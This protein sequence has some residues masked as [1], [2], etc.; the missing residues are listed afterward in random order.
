MF[1]FLQVKYQLVMELSHFQPPD[2]CIPRTRRNA[3]RIE[4]SITQDKGKIGAGT[5]LEKPS[6]MAPTT[7]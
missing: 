1:A 4:V 7:S 3:G 2:R 5:H 6:G